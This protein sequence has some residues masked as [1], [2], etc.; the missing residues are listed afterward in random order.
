MKENKYFR[1]DI[2][3]MPNDTKDKLR[4]FVDIPKD[5]IGD[6][7]VYVLKVGKAVYKNPPKM[8]K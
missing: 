8:K 6:L 2:Y 5:K 7:I 3:S 4:C 1:V